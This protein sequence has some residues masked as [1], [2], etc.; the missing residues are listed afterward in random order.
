MTK[1]EVSITSEQI[2]TLKRVA[3]DAAEQAPKNIHLDRESLQRVIERGDELRSA[4][5][6]K[7]RELAKPKF[8]YDKTKDAWELIEDIGFVPL[9][10][11]P[12]NLE[13][14]AF[15]K[16]DENSVT[17]EVM[18]ERARGDLNANLGQQHAEWLLEH[19]AEIPEEFRKYYL[20][21]TGTIWRV[22][23][24]DR[25]VPCLGW[26][27]NKWCLGFRWLG[28]GGWGGRGRLLRLRE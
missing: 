11:S 27:G 24:G 17:G 15:L 20:V 16:S 1:K 25:N 8:V 9:I 4:I 22:S 14:V 13:F 10:T 26:S 21:F 5:F 18:L 2:K 3:E 12:K 7:V 28:S 19:Q 23:V 6:D